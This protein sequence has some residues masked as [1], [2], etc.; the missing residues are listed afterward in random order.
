[1]PRGR[2]V[3]KRLPSANLVKFIE[4]HQLTYT[5]VS[6]VMEINRQTLVNWLRLGIPEQ[7]ATK[8]ASLVRRTVD[9]GGRLET[10]TWLR[11]EE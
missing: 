7:H 8:L 11:S 10:L 4:R 6:Q 9:R 5:Y 2:D 3:F 1:M